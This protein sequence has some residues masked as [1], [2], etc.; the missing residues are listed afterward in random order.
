MVFDTVLLQPVEKQ[1]LMMLQEDDMRDVNKGEKQP[2]SQAFG[3][4]L[5][6]IQA[7]PLS[8]SSP[9]SLYNA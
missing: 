9:A 7:L 3:Q 4:H 5:V 8:S 6:S 1:N 2:L